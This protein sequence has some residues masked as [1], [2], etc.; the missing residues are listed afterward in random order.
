[1]HMARLITVAALLCLAAAPATAQDSTG[2]DPTVTVGLVELIVAKQY[3]AF[4]KELL[5][6]DMDVNQPTPSGKLPICEAVKTG[7]VRFVDALI[8]HGV[9]VS[10]KQPYTGESP[11]LIAMEYNL[12]EIAELLLAYGADPEAQAK[13]GK[14][15]I[16]AASS[17]ALKAVVERWKKDGAMAFEDPP[18]SWSRAES[19]EH[20]GGEYWYNSGAKFGRWNM[21][22]SCGWQRV[23]QQAEL[24]VFVNYVTG[25]TVFRPPPPLCW[26]KLRVESQEL[27]Y[28]YAANI[29]V[30][31][32]PDE[33]PQ[34][35]VDEFS[36]DLNVRWY[37]P[38]TSEYSWEDPVTL[39][40]WRAMSSDEGTFYYNIKT[41]ESSWD[42]PVELA[43]EKHEGTGGQYWFN[44]NTQESQWGDPE[45][46]AWVRQ[47]AE[48]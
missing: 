36:T 24:P 11:I 8:Q 48:L 4:V 14:T 42:K 2:A 39:S 20:A 28:N 15:A 21:P 17:D 45:H 46:V 27:W 44:T 7:D 40:S 3:D 41:G 9:I 33:L 13:S 6:A 26:R 38:V 31:H 30:T 5:R 23:E 47:D 1:M 16:E 43:W 22:P 19:K 12:P 18:G 35:L 25:Q 34:Y 29:S 10:V 37:N 32:A